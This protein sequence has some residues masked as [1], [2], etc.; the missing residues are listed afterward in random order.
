MKACEY[1]GSDFVP[2][3]AEQVYCCRSHAKAASK[4][5]AEERR[6]IREMTINGTG[7]GICPHPYKRT[8][9]S[10]EHAALDRFQ[11]EYHELY[12]CVC[13]GLHYTSNLTRNPNR[14]KELTNNNG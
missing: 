11:A 6:L 5:R 14:V 1:C 4:K 13:G 10:P 3:S 7:H 9:N 8:Y 12:R 2:S